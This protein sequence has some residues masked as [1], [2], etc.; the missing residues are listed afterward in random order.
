MRSG[1]LL[2]DL[3]SQSLQD[4]TPSSSQEILLLFFAVSLITFPSRGEQEIRRFLSFDL[5]LFSS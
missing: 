2:L 1:L 3:I 4:F 5:T